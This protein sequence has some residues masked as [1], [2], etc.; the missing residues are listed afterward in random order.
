[1]TLEEIKTKTKRFKKMSDE[2]LLRIIDGVPPDNSYPMLERFEAQIE[3]HKRK[4]KS[5]RR[6][7]CM[8][9][10]ILALTAYL[11]YKEFTKR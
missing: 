6:M 3:L 1:M 11:A 2:Q 5:E 9:F 7:I 8:T 10:I 4:M